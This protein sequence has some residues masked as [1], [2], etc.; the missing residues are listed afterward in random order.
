[1]NS[2][3]WYMSKTLFVNIVALVATVTGA[4][5]L[6]LGLT[7]EVQA[8]VAVGVMAVVNIILRLITSRPIGG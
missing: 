5:G 3:S 1:M 7:P 4:F 2:K 6:D 8:E